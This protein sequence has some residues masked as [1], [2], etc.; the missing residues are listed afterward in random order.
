M[1]RGGPFPNDRRAQVIADALPI[2]RQRIC[3]GGVGPF[4]EHSQQAIEYL[5]QNHLGRLLDKIRTPCLP[6]QGFHP[7]SM[8]GAV[9]LQ[10]ETRQGNQKARIAR[11]L[12]CAT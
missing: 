2:P 9:G 7:M 1:R 11:K 12:G 10:S 6:I 8:H 3:F 5:L 4:F